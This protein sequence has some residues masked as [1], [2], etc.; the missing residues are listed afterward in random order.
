M[1]CIPVARGQSVRQPHHPPHSDRHS[2]SSHIQ[3][4][5]GR[6]RWDNDGL[7]VVRHDVGQQREQRILQPE[8][9]RARAR[10]VLHRAHLTQKDQKTQRQSKTVINYHTK[11]YIKLTCMLFWRFGWA[12]LFLQSIWNWRNWTLRISS[13]RC[14]NNACAQSAHA[15]LF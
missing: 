12:L 3:S 6:F 1:H 5:S 9:L 8:R 2:G 4:R 10:A 13:A 15:W 11:Y 7:W 14:A